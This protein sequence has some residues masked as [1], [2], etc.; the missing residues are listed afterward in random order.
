MRSQQVLDQMVLFSLSSF[1]KQHFIQAIRWFL[2]WSSCSKDSWFKASFILGTFHDLQ[3]PLFSGNSIISIHM[4]SMK[5]DLAYILTNSSFQKPCSLLPLSMALLEHLL[6]I[7]P[8]HVSLTRREHLLP[9]WI[10]AS[11]SNMPVKYSLLTTPV[12]SHPW[13]LLL[14]SSWSRVIY[15]SA[16]LVRMM[17]GCCNSTMVLLSLQQ[18]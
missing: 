13:T 14:L 7:R 17:L 16:S 11:L 10:M 8:V 5:V 4:D 9:A 2:L 3:S 15:G 6:A 12:H 18:L 1:F